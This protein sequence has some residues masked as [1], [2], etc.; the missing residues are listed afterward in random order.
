MP[1]LTYGVAAGTR[2]DQL[3]YLQP[4][5][6]AG[7][8]SSFDR[9]TFDATHGNHDLGNFLSTGPDGNV[10]LDQAGPG[11]VYRIWMTSQQAAFPDQWIKVFFNGSATPAIDMTIGQMFAGT[12]APFLA[13]LV[14]DSTQS[15]GGYVSYVPLCYRTSVKVTTSMNRY[16]NIGYESFPPGTDIT[17]WSPG[18]STAALQQ[19]WQ[20]VTVDPISAAGN[21]VVSGQISLDPNVPQTIAGIAGPSSIQS[22]K[23]TIPGVTAAAGT[24]AER[25]LDDTWIRIFW[26]GQAGPAVSAP[27]G[28]FFG[29]G[30]FGSY[31]ARGLVA[32]MDASD[33]LYM[34]LPMPF[35][36]H[37]TVQL[38]DTGSASLPAIGYQIQ[39]QPFAGDFARVGYLTTQYT[40]TTHG[41]FGH[42]IPV[43]YAAG[44]GKFV[45]VTASYTGGLSRSYL[46]GDE[47]IYVDGSRSPAFYGTGTEDFFNGGYY[48]NHGP[49]SQPLTGN[50]AHVVAGGADQTAA[51]RFFVQDAIPFRR[52]LVVTLQHGPYDNTTDTSASMLAYYYQRPSVQSRLTD[53]LNV[54]NAASER[55][56]RYQVTGQ[57]WHRIS[58]YTYPG[59]ADSTVITDT[60]RGYRGHSQFTLAITRGNQGVD[61][62]RRY[63]A[64][65]A[66]QKAH[67]Y[68]GGQLAGTW[69]VAGGNPYH[70][71]GD[72][73]FLIP[74]ALTAGKRTITVRIQYVAGA[75]LTDY[76]YWAY[77]ITP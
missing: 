24:A 35:R 14:A 2:L 47:R 8:V 38:V 11:C 18:Q 50:T 74:A 64:G 36:Q 28:S 40:T 21:T 12:N 51:Y 15:S 5:T 60:G 31:P 66:G 56:H 49:Y 32:G 54:G 46:E 76:A 69:Y 33:T 29:L 70:R 25:V 67:V 4:E 63:D 30:Q 61:L 6:M 17:T 10:M 42:D 41:P 39:Y 22:V 58:R 3:P 48:F 45:G 57:A 62:R 73:D 37:A 27:V 65:V 1:G 23:L 7:G 44:S 55:A 13:P 52:R 43:L 9:D 68:V 16:F 75:D 19:E 34:Y 59:T 77:S 26:D 71:R 72:T 53:T 20:N